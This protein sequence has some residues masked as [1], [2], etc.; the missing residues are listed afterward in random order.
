[1]SGLR[2]NFYKSVVRGV[3]VA[4][5]MV[6]EF[7]T[8][9][10]CSSKKLPLKHLGL[11]LGAS[12][13]RRLTWRPVVEK[14]KKKLSSWKR[15]V[16]SFS[17]RV[18]L[19]KFVLSALPMYYSSIFKMLECVAKEID[20]IQASFLWGDSEFIR[21]LHLV[22]WK[23]VCSELLMKMK[24]LLWVFSLFVERGVAVDDFGLVGMITN[25]G[26]HP[27]PTNKNHFNSI[28]SSLWKEE[29][30][31]L[32]WLDS[33]QP[34]SV[35][36]VNFGSI[37]VMPPLQLI[38][39]AWGLASSNQTFLWIIRPDLVV[40]DS[41]ILPPDF[42]SETKERS[43]LASWCPQEQVLNHPAI[44]GF[45]THSGWNSTLESIC[46][47]VPM[48]CWPFFA[49]QQTNCWLCCGQWGVGM[50]INNDFKREEVERMVRELMAGE[51]GKEMKRKVMEWK[52]LG[53]EATTCS[54]GS[55]YLNFE[56]MVRFVLMSAGSNQSS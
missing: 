42:V 53:E 35:I 48:L 44:G 27:T 56:K 55:S 47:G 33:K 37:T 15:R 4:D 20:R 26:L 24:L 21:K 30:E 25:S 23:E 43:L 11:P 3:G 50:E 19:I 45:L 28:G 41:A 51:R 8:K 12:P 40:G 13:S 17:S 14:F 6:K 54:V 2:I 34:N 9:L 18:T 49:D 38:E 1:M 46:S 5:E 31:C 10:N 16:L 7:P 36:Y 29:T 52:K 39:F 22:R 32:S